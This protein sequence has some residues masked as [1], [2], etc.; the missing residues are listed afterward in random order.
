MIFFFKNSLV[1]RLILRNFADENE[2][3]NN[4]NIF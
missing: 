2:R 3:D 4:E 1:V